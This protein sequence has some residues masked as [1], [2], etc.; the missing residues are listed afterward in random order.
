[1]TDLEGILPLEPDVRKEA[2]LPFAPGALLPVLEHVA[3]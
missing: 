1:M 2:A 3:G